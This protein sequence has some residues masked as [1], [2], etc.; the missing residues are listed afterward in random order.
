M[1]LSF[2]LISQSIAYTLILYSGSSQVYKDVLALVVDTLRQA[3]YS[4]TLTSS[5][6]T[7]LAEESEDTPS[8]LPYFEMVFR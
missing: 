6:L 5:S 7:E 8:Y 1:N 3:I 2:V 4:T